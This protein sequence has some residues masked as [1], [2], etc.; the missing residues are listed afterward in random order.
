[1][2][3]AQ[4]TV[5]QP[6]GGQDIH[7]YNATMGYG[8]YDTTQVGCFT[9]LPPIG[10]CSNAPWW[11]IRNAGHGRETEVDVYDA[12]P[13]ATHLLRQ[14]TTQYLLTCPAPNVSA[15]PPYTGTWGNWNG[16]RVSQLDHNNPVAVCRVLPSQEDAYTLDGAAQAS[17]P[18]TTT[19]YA[20]DNLNR[21]MD[22]TVNSNG[23][24][25]AT[26]SPTTIVTH[27]DYIQDDAITTSLT[28]A[29]GRF[30]IDFPAQ[31]YTRD[32]GNTVHY[33]CSQTT[34][35]GAAYATGQQATLTPRHE[36]TSDTYTG[37]GTSP[38]F[39]LS[40]QLR[41]SSVFDNWGNALASNDADANAGVTGHTGC[42]YNGTQYTSCNALDSTFET[43]PISDTNALNQMSTTGYTSSTSG[44]F[45]LGPTST[46]DFNGQVATYGY[47]ALG[48]MTSQTLPGETAGLS[49]TSWIYTVW[50]EPSG[51]QAP[52]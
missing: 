17:S 6:D 2:G 5:N 14:T 39:A 26:G 44:G 3:F 29:T 11:D 49:T 20:Y 42:T 15:T 27:T 36:T 28:S 32:S 40:A 23:G 31:V 4:A 50:C 21:A 43:L 30:L 37:C 16:N 18:H 12:P 25:G 7:T 47:D 8:I 41:T 19:T 34:Y 33:S 52:S 46:T 51:P 48:R 38:S 13:N 10:P 9:A 22:E 45:G 35:D 1:M 24:G